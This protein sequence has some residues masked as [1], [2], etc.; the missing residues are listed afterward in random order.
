MKTF[1]ELVGSLS[2]FLWG[3]PMIIVMLL[4]GSF[5]IYKT[6]AWVFKNFGYIFK[7][8][9]GRLFEKSEATEADEKSISPVQAV[10]TALAGTIGAGNIVGVATAIK[11]GGPGAIFWLWVAALVNMTTK[12][13]EITLAVATREKDE[14]GEF[15]GG[16][17]YYLENGL[18]MR[19]L[20]ILFSVFGAIAI[21]GTGSLVQSNAMANS[22]H[23]LTGLD[24]RIIGIAIMILM[25]VIIIGGIK[26]I[27]AFAEKIVPLM[28]VLY[29][30]ATVVILVIYRKELL[31]TLGYIVKDAFQPTAAVGG[32]AGATVLIT[33]RHGLARGIFSNEAGLG[34]A[35]MAHAAAHT[36]HPVRQGMWGAVEVF[37]SS[38]L[39]CTMTALVVICSG[40]WT[41]ANIDA[42][43]LTAAAFEKAL[44]VGGEMLVSIGL[45]F[46]AF[47]T[48]VSWYYYGD[49]CISYITKS[50]A[51]R[52]IYRLVYII[53]SVVGSL[54]GL[55]FVWSISDVANAL[56]VIP[57]FIGLIL[58]SKQLVWLVRDFN[59]HYKGKGKL[60]NYDWTFD[61]HWGAVFNR[62][63]VKETQVYES[64]DYDDN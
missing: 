47:T 26:R 50:K 40:L 20:A 15:S 27:G 34:S 33:I 14:N 41:D 28:S 3:I 7:N 29:L 51:V 16:P 61:N 8:T 12:F 36:D 10:S 46:F 6:R 21:L 43:K 9:F 11:L 23:T 49:K 2:D 55:K 17:M 56:M 37:V 64:Y 54:G 53:F 39:I 24:L 30:G 44:P 60:G 38:V 42:N 45:M 63:K 1:I 31:P 52:S 48:L 22:I 32:F 4:G 59:K 35:P 13:A 58:L 25:I 62:R 57:N 18:N 19:W 5:L